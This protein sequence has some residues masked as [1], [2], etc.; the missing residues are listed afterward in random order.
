MTMY[1][2]TEQMAKRAAVAIHAAPAAIAAAGAH[3]T[4]GLT[5]M[6]GVPGLPVITPRMVQ[7]DSYEGMQALGKSPAEIHAMY[8]A[9][10][11]KDPLFGLNAIS[12]AGD[13]KST[14]GQ[15]RKLLTNKGETAVQNRFRSPTPAP[16]LQQA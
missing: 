8:A 2:A 4:G 11:A 1:F 5:T 14:G 9:E 15:A 16:L 13:A 7:H 12:A 10:K 6:H 3:R